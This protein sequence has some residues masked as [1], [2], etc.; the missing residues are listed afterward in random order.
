MGNCFAGTKHFVATADTTDLKLKCTYRLTYQPDS[1]DSRSLLT[2]DMLLYI[3][4][5]FSEFQSLNNSLLDSVVVDL[6]QKGGMEYL[7]KNGIDASVLPKTKFKYKI[8]K[9]YPKGEITVVDKI[10]TEKYR[11]AEPKNLF[12]WK[13]SPEKATIAGYNCQKATTEFGG[14]KYEAWFTSELPISEGPYKFNGLPGLIV[15]VNDM[16]KHY[17]FELISLKQP[18]EAA[19]VIF[20]SDRL[21]TTTKIEFNKGLK[22]FNDN[23]VARLGLNA[24]EEV[25][26]RAKERAKKRNNPIEL[27]E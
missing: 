6:E 10:L 26:R 1:T 15:K 16:E 7:Q 21:I 2:E 24:S 13:I 22:D 3:G 23:M 5:S 17:T 11:Y 4:D 25:N 9:N 27:A 20:P 14:R 19:K 8:Y 18:K 12:D